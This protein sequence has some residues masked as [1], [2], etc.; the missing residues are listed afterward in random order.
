MLNENNK[1]SDE[2]NM[3]DVDY[4]V[5]RIQ[6]GDVVSG[7]VISANNSE[8]MVNIGYITD[9][10]VPKSEVGEED[11]DL[12]K[13]FKEGDNIEVYVEQINDGE[14]NVL[15][16]KKKADKIR[17]WEDLRKSLKNKKT[18]EVIVEDKVKGGV[19][20][21]VKGIRAFIPLSQLSTKSVKNVDEFMGK[22][23]KVRAIEV[24]EDKE[25]LVM[26]RKA[27]EQ[28]ELEMKAQNVWESLEKGQKRKGVV[29]KLMKFGAFVDLGGVEG[30]IHISQMSW[31]RVNDPSEV[32]SVGDNVEVYVLDFDRKEN[33]ISLALKDITRDTWNDFTQTY[34]QGN[35][36]EGKVVKLLNFGAFVEIYDGVEGLVHVSEI[37]DDKIAKPSDKLKIGDKVKVKILEI[38]N[39]N[40]KVSLSIKEAI[41]KPVENY[42][43]FTDS[44]DIGTNLGELLK[45]KLKDF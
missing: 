8:I 7:K 33:K 17:V 29:T 40:K 20:T 26:S 39:E 32:V 24:N 19:I 22:T 12:S 34:T 35:V 1:N 21:H 5:K 15:L 13:R 2:F 30:L 14:G 45:D 31:N 42:S 16:S 11:I 37:T 4:S 27:V 25:Q 10:I 28:E 18:Y 43:E 44:Q 36:L 41:D 23:M 38:D 3:N 9:G 6:V